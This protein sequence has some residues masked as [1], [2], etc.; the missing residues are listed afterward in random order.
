MILLCDIGNTNTHLGLADSKRVVS[1]ANIP[2]A[3]WLS[4]TARKLVAKFG[5]EDAKFIWAE[6]HPDT[7]K[8]LGVEMDDIIEISRGDG[9]IEVVVTTTQTQP[10]GAQV[11]VFSPDGKLYQPPGLSFAAWPRYNTATGPGNDAD[12]NGQGN[13]GYGCYG[14]NVGIGNIDDDP[15]LEELFRDDPVL[16]ETAIVPPLPGITPL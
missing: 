10:T 3:A 12:F 2:T 13:H 7:A 1:Q 5:E 15:E 8:A 9:K 6:M 16:L 14:E 11:F 4:G